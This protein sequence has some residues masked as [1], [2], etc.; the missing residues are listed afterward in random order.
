[1]DSQPLSE[2]VDADRT[3]RVDGIVQE[4]VTRLSSGALKDAPVEEVAGKLQQALMDAGLPEQPHSWVDST[5]R[6]IS[7][8]RT[9]ITDVRAAIDPDETPTS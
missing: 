4:V 3:L 5:A 1:M 9:V 6:E 2:D 7:G 8:G